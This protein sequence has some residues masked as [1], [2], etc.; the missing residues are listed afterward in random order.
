MKYKILVVGGTF[1]DVK[2][3][4]KSGYKG[5]ISVD[6]NNTF[7]T[8]EDNSTK[9]EYGKQSGLITKLITNLISYSSNITYY[10]GGNYYELND[11]LNDTPNYDIVFWFANVDNDLP[12]IRDVKAVA[13]KVMLVTSKRN[14]NSKYTT[15][16]VVQRALASKSNLIFEFSKKEDLFNMRV[17]DPLGCMWYDGTN[18]KE[19]ID[20]SMNR[21][22]YLRS[23]TRQ[24]TTKSSVDKGLVLAWYFDQFKEN[25]YKSNKV[26]DIP[27]E[28]D[29][30]D[31]VKQYATRFYEILNPGPKV[32]RFLGNASMRPKNPPQV[33]R[34]SRGMPSFRSNGYIFVSQRNIDKKFIDL[35]HF[36]PCYL[37]NNKVYYCGDNKPSV[38]TPIQLRLYELF[39]NINYMIHAHVYMKD[40]P[41]TELAIPCGAIEEVAEIKR[42]I[43][44][45]YDSFTENRYVINLKGHGSIIMG[46]TI[47]DIKNISY[48]GRP[49]PEKFC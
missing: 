18:L 44:H 45:Y 37:E 1:N 21:L 31:L 26:I 11:I 3:D 25:Q 36:V 46:N 28:Q 27:N 35:N 38:D 20:S 23:I 2:N 40:A 10:N 24:S 22:S 49:M 5:I 47:D 12:K 17:I 14:D 41:Y 33:G 8:I 19:A 48:F 15:M 34:C 16:E 39:P 9:V 7:N 32:E 13:P 30:I 4:I 42:T 43:E 29:F 6:E